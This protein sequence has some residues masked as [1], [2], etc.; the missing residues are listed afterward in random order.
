MLKAEGEN[1]IVIT[2][3]KEAN[4]SIAMN[5][6]NTLSKTY[7]ITAIGLQ[8]YTKMQSI[9]IEHLHNLK[10]HYLSPY[11]VDY[12][13]PSVISFIEK[14]RT[15]FSNEPTQ[16]SFQGYDIALHFM[17]SLG[18]N[19]RNFNASEPVKGVQLLQADYHFR[20]V[21]SLGGY[22]N[23]TFYIVEY[24]DAYEVKSTGKFLAKPVEI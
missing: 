8:E 24:T 17:A 6:L 18:K 13:N 14:Y 16:Y 4:V 19:G 5:R 12:S 1:I 22:M 23:H 3:G 11:F 15:A 7:K 20:R 2:E 21:A 10:L 9:D